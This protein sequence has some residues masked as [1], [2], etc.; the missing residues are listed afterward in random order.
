[1]ILRMLIPL[2]FMYPFIP[3]STHIFFR[4][5][6]TPVYVCAVWALWTCLFRAR[7]ENGPG[8]SMGR[9]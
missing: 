9:Q 7:K 5:G 2:P 3:S 6:Q 8:F 4:P 1:M